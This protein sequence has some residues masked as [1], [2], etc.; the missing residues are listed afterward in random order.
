MLITN[1]KPVFFTGQV[2]SGGTL[3]TRI[4][5]QSNELKV[6]YDTIHYMR[7]SFKNYYPLEN[8]YDQLLNEINYRINKRWELS[9]NIKEIK[10]T[11]SKYSKITEAVVYD[12]IMRSFLRISNNDDIRWGD[13]TALKWEGI[14]PFL[15]MFPHGKVIVNYRD[16]RAILASYKHSTYLPEPMYLDVI[17]STLALFN[18]ISS[19]GEVSK[20][21]HLIRYEDLISEKL[22]NS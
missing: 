22:I 5:D 7:F 17:F 14:K 9:I 8:K 10:D 15:K 12:S 21:V 11:I 18:Y 6:A 3:L 20:S 1:S 16:P 2:R 13:R 4:F 19:L